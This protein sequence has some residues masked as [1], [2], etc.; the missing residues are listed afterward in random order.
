M[1]VTWTR[2]EG[3]WRLVFLLDPEDG[4]TGACTDGTPVELRTNSCHVHTG[5]GG[6]SPHPDLLAL[7]AWTVVAPWTRRRV[8]FDRPISPG[9][10]EA[11]R[12][13][14]GVD[15]GPVGEDARSGARLAV[16]YSGGADSMAVAAMF[17]DAPFVHFQRVSHPRVP[18]RWTHYRAEVLADLAR[19]SGRELHIVPSDL[20]FLLSRPRPGYPE[21]HA[22]TVGALLLADD[23]DLGGVALGYEMGSRWLDNGRQA[24]RFASD[25]PMWATHGPWGRLYAAAGV[26]LVLPVGGVSEP[27]TMRMALGSDLAHLVRW[28]LRGDM[29]GPCQKCGKC[30]RKE[31]ILAA[32]EGRPLKTTLTAA[33]VPARVW[34]QP[35]PYPGQETIEY[36]CARVP[37]IETT[38]FARA[39][40]HLRATVES[41][42]WMDRCY[43][44]AIDETP[45]PWRGEVG[46]YM[47]EHIGLMTADEQ[48]QVEA[49][50]AV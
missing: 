30:L 14:W 44:P 21:H 12:T 16:S 49:W 38:P 2:D 17:P 11:L 23:L 1:R 27:V 7:S 19:R 24:D 18:N 20:E 3:V 13:G 4:T 50:T 8:T 39:A 26:P 6:G 28:C 37:G 10:A 41:T 34:Q 43:P 47:R 35:P 33:S 48:R 40:E 29:S 5:A 15:A 45:E 9:L 46:A 42:R 25:N 32:V 36:G 31:L 22:V